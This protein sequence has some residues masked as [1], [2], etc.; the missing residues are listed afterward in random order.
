MKRRRQVKLTNTKLIFANGLS[1]RN[2]LKV[3]NHCFF[4]LLLRATGHKIYPT[5]MAVFDFF[6]EDCHKKDF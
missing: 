4:D 5:E 3:K 1:Y 2:N 6:S